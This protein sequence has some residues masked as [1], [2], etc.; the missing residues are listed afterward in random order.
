[1]KVWNRLLL[2]ARKGRMESELTDE[3]RLHREL[4]EE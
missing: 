2:R 4:L 3:I 1:M